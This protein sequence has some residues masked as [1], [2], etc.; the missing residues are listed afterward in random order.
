M[1]GA[2]L[3]DLSPV[4]VGSYSGRQPLS[5]R[6]NNSSSAGVSRATMLRCIVSGAHA[7]RATTA[8]WARSPFSAPRTIARSLSTNQHQGAPR[9]VSA[10]LDG[11]MEL[12][13]LKAGK[14]YP[15]CACGL[16]KKQP[17][18]DGSHRREDTG[19]SPLRFKPEEDME[20]A[21]FCTCKATSTPPFCDGTHNELKEKQET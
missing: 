9:H 6:S 4:L 5:T 11:P 14:V 18:C 7:A 13:N 10:S 20:S 19:I 21:W 8:R 16:S 2:N 12:K 3:I 17:L 15:W 1:T